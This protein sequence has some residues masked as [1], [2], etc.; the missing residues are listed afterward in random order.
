MAHNAGQVASEPEE[1]ARLWPVDAKNLVRL[2][3]ETA[4]LLLFGN[5]HEKR[6]NP[7]ILELVGVG[8]RLPRISKCAH[9]YTKCTLRLSVPTRHGKALPRVDVEHP[10]PYH[11][12]TLPG[13]RIS[14]SNRDP[15]LEGD[16]ALRHDFVQSGWLTFNQHGSACDCAKRQSHAKRAISWRMTFSNR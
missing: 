4:K 7:P 15:K 3:L 13:L 10:P 8:I 2:R 14:T 11:T 5:R 1:L 16:A 9:L 12:N 6:S